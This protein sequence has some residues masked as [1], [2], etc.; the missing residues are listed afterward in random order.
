MEVHLNYAYSSLSL[1]YSGN[2]STLSD[3]AAAT[4]LMT[5]EALKKYG[6]TPLARIIGKIMIKYQ[7]WTNQFEEIKNQLKYLSYL[8][9][10]AISVCLSVLPILTHE[11][12][13]Q[14]API[15]FGGEFGRTMGIFLALFWDFNLSRFTSL[16]RKNS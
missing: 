10:V 3:G 8:Y 1:Y 5:E 7:I 14:L 16:I 12:S 13:D 6:G 4:V 9:K 15:F 2:A 11:L